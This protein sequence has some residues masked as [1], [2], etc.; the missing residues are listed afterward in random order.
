M[1]HTLKSIINRLTTENKRLLEE[2]EELKELI[3][4]LKSVLYGGTYDES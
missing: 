4:E 3:Y 1:E 2:I